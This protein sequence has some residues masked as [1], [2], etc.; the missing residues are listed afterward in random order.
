MNLSLHKNLAPPFVAIDH[1][2]IVRKTCPIPK[3]SAKICIYYS[4]NCREVGVY[5]DSQ[6]LQLPRRDGDLSN[7]DGAPKQIEW[8]TPSHGCQPFLYSSPFPYLELRAHWPL[9]IEAALLQMAMLKSSGWRRSIM[10]TTL[11][12]AIYTWELWRK[13]IVN[14]PLR[15]TMVVS[16]KDFDSL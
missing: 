1:T 15:L 7:V 6:G 12:L 8:P 14:L 4:R 3:P 10:I 16:L 13:T 11:Q 5:E 9:L 2:W